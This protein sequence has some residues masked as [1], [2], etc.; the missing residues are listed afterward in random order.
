[1][2][3]LLPVKVTSALGPAL[4]QASFLAGN[5]EPSTLRGPVV[6]N[7]MCAAIHRQSNKDL[8]VIWFSK[9]KSDLQTCLPFAQQD[10]SGLRVPV[11]ESTKG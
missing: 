1:M 5:A 2:S 9:G 10:C 6:D 4:S 7:A 8:S 3:P 11:A